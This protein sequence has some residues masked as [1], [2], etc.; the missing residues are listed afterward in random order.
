MNKC[1]CCLKKIDSGSY[2][3]KSCLIKL[4]GIGKL[5]LIK[6]ASSELVSE[7]SKNIGKMSISGIQIKALVKLNKKN[8]LIEIVQ[9][10]GTHILKPEPSEYPELPQNENLCMNIASKLGMEV[11]PHGLF[12]MADRKICYIVRR[13]DRDAD[14]SKLHVEDM[15]QLLGM[16]SE[17]KY[18]SSIEKVGKM[19]IRVSKKPFLDLINF[20][21]RIIFCFLIGNGDMHL[22][23]WS[24]LLLNDGNICL[25]PCY[26]LISS[27][28][29]IAE[30]DETA[31]TINGKRNSLKLSDFREL[32]KYLKIDDKASQNVIDKFKNAKEKILNM[33]DYEMSVER[34]KKLREII[35]ERYER[36]L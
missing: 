27:K 5:P 11:P 35:L 10:R 19:I 23:N 3:H 8:N 30:E 4:F 26:D 7:I 28:L 16:S 12:Y 24:I 17:A 13:F 34:I 2:Y 36:I 1:L 32:A 21:E 15:A 29:Y 22:K 33:L 31:L 25:S 14:G 18:E 9:T 20:Y 6:F